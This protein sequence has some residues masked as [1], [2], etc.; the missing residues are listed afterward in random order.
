MFVISVS[1]VGTT[2]V[3]Q[4]ALYSHISG[5]DGPAFTVTK[6]F[7]FCLPALPAEAVYFTAEFVAQTLS[8]EASECLGA[9][10]R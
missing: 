2:Q 7:S 8:Q 10:V 3:A 5:Q 6:H 1:E 4:G 9:T